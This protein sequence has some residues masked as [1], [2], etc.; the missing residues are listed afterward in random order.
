L[1][2]SNKKNRLT[3]VSGG[4]TGVDRASWDAAIELGLSQEG[5][6]PKGRIAE[7]GTI[8]SRYQCRETSGADYVERTEKNIL[9]SDATLVLGFGAA[10][11][12]TKLT[13][14]L[15][16]KH[17]RPYLWMDLDSRPV[18]K[19]IAEG[20]LFLRKERPGRLNV[21]GP[22]GSSRANVYSRALDYVK[23]LLSDYTDEWKNS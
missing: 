6:V 2:S 1:K 10:S 23:T 3:I 12:G 4:Q 22:R 20:L 17:R 16:E 9:D 13:I 5:W 8:A 15:C 14:D 21:A 19:A 7:D 18:E 11:G